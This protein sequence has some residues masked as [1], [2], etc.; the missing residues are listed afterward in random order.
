MTL[1]VACGLKRE[2]RIVARASGDVV[3]VIGGGDA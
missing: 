2:A 3:T 1:I